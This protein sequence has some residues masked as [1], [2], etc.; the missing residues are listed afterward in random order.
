VLL[1]RQAGEHGRRADPDAPAASKA[2]QSAP[3]D[4][5]GKVLVGDRC[6]AACPALSELARVGQ[7]DL[8]QQR[9]QGGH[10]QE[11][12]EVRLCPWLVEAIQ[13]VGELLTQRRPREHGRS[14][15]LAGLSAGRG[16]GRLVSGEP[17][18]D[19]VLHEPHPRDIRGRVEARA[20]G[21]ARGTQQPVAALPCAHQLGAHPGALAGL[22]DP[23]KEGGCHAET[24][25]YLDVI[26]T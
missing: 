3:Q 6:V 5:G 21:R 18:G 9:L 1:T 12:V 25:Q 2:E 22:A 17:S 24:I 13:R 19:V 15:L 16:G 4:S 14:R 11:P 8:A 10:S 20:P 23:Q 7:H 26:W